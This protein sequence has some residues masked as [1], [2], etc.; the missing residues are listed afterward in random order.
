MVV[1]IRTSVCLEFIMLLQQTAP[2]SQGF[3]I[4]QDLLSLILRLL[5]QLRSAS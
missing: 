3:V 1:K 4:T 5:S 2:K